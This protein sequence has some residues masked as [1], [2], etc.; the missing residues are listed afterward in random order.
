MREIFADIA[1]TDLQPR[2]LLCGAMVFFLLGAGVV[3]DAL[4]AA[5]LAATPPD[6]RRLTDRLRLRP[7]SWREGVVIL[8]VL[9]LLQGVLIAAVSIESRWTAFASDAWSAASFVLK[10]SLFHVAGLLTVLW[11]MHRRGF[12]WPA[13]FGLRSSG[14]RTR[15]WLGV[16]LYVGALP[17]VAVGAWTYR[18]FLFAVRYPIEPQSV[19]Q[20]FA[21]STTPLWVQA[22]LVAL[23]VLVAPFIEELLFRGILL[24]LLLRHARPVLA[25]SMVSLLFATLHLHVPSLVPLFLI[26]TA[27]SLAYIHSGSILVPTIMHALFNGVSLLAFYLIRDAIG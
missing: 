18:L 16:V 25:V 14:W 8:W 20:L 3:V 17:F 12:G 21:E 24:P 15:A 2:L 27:F 5:R 22:Y 9:L 26:A 19:V 13:A 11:L 23:A 4:V 7:W 6:W 10:T 1:P